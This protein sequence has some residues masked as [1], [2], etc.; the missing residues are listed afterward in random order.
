MKFGF[1]QTCGFGTEAV[2][3]DLDK[4]QRMT[5]TSGTFIVSCIYLIYC[6]V[7]L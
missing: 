2:C 7:Q 1:I 5:L 6:I 3:V 4:G